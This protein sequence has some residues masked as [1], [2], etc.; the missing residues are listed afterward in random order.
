MDYS[1]LIGIHDTVKG[2]SSNIRD[3]TLTIF[4]PKEVAAN[5]TLSK[6]AQLK[7]AL[8]ESDLVQL[9]PSSARLPEMPPPERTYCYFYQDSGGFAA[10]DEMNL[11]EKEI[12]YI[13]IIDVLTY[14]D[15]GKK[16]EHFFRSIGN[17][18]VSS[19]S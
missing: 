18:P 16:L 2:N 6:A 13:G 14:Y 3:N 8:A 5:S 1:L 10:T 11:P 17:D 9:G 12:Y 19:P 4:E 7:E 15:T